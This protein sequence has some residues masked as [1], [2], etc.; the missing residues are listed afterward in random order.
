M[1]SFSE[2]IV[3]FLS[4]KTQSYDV[5]KLIEQLITGLDENTNPII[6]GRTLW[7]VSQFSEVIS[8]PEVLLS[9]FK[10]SSL[11]LDKE[12][13]VPVRLTAVKSIRSFAS[14]IERAVWKEL[15]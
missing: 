8:Q 13:P 15:D 10:I 1:G 2:D 11:Y 14:K 3:M 6:K 4:N 7:T 5:S 9:L 12:N